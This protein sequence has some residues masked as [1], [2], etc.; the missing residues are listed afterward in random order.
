MIGAGGL[1]ARETF[2]RSRSTMKVLQR[3]RQISKTGE[4]IGKGV[5]ERQGYR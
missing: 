1:A 5:G 4:R 2:T 3:T